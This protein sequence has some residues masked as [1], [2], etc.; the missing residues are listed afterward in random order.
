M[1]SVDP[2]LSAVSQL[3]HRLELLRMRGG[4]ELTNRVVLGGKL[5]RE[6]DTCLDGIPCQ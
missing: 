4:I 2:P 6:S 1:K 5:V 3:G